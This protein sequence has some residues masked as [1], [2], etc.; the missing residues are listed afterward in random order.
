MKNL[1]IIAYDISNNKKRN[2]MADLLS[3]WG[4]RINLS[5][6]ECVFT[7]KQLEKTKE[8]IESLIDNNTDSVKIYFICK[9]CYSKSSVLGIQEK[10]LYDTTFFE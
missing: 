1:Y 10:Y 5:V 2:R 7:K 4:R 9:N 6:F 3:K 8:K